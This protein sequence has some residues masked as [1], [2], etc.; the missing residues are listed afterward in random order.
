ML[1]KLDGMENCDKTL[2]AGRILLVAVFILGAINWIVSNGGPPI[3]MIAGK[4]IPA[5]ALVGWIALVLK[6]GGS[7]LVLLG[8]KTRVGCLMLV[9][10][11]LV[12]AFGWHTPSGWPIDGTFLKELSMIGG[13]LILMT[14][15]PGKYS[16]DAKNSGS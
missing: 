15:G 14:T 3:G 16:L 7:I 4:G 1:D 12:T 11:T 13:I 10:F 5:A 6:L 9:V 2:L 8:F